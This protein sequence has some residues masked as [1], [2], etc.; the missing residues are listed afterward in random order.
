MSSVKI[1]LGG[2]NYSYLGFILMDDEYALI[3]NMQP[4]TLPHYPPLLAIPANSTLIQALELK[5]KYQEAKRLYL[6]C[7]NIKKALLRH[8]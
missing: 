4:F 2:G 3:P 8:I 5:D 7:K 6:E 1:D